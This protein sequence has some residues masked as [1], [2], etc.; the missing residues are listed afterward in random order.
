MKTTKNKPSISI[1]VPLY[2]VEPYI[3]DCL[4]SVANQK[5]EG[6][7]ECI[8]VDDC[9][10][11]RSLELASRFIEGYVGPI[12]FSILH[13]K[14]NGGLSSARNDGSNSCKGDY[15]LF[16]DSDDE[17][18]DTALISLT[19]PLDDFPYDFVIANYVTLGANIEGPR[20]LMDEGEVEK[21][22]IFPSFLEERWYMMAFNKLTKRQFILDNSLYF[23]DGLIHEDNI[24]SFKY[25]YYASSMY[26]LRS[27][28][29][30]YKVRPGSI[31]TSEN[32]KGRLDAL[33][34]IYGLYVDFINVNKLEM[35]PI[36][37]NFLQTFFLRAVQKAKENKAIVSFSKVY[38]NLRKHK[39]RSGGIRLDKGFVRRYVR[40]FHLLLP[41]SLSII[42][43]KLL[44][45]GVDRNY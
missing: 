31:T 24:W 14:D 3:I 21:D 37:W 12:K 32:I 7:I 20:L 10:T 38:K 6:A 27:N 9:G 43:I 42:Y 39:L 16:L 19:A 4:M 41:G 33:Q 45:W 29:Y 17:L 23:E 26:V 13:R 2:N 22:R 34:T 18:T 36:L 30:I 28:C 40:D 35:T 5:Y 15:I 11:D 44:L 1:V 8:I 25:A